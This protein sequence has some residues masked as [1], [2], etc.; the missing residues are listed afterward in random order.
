MRLRVARKVFKKHQA[1]TT[2]Y[3]QS[4][5]DRANKRLGLAPK[6]RMVRHIVIKELAG[7]IPQVTEEARSE[8][9]AKID[10]APQAKQTDTDYS[11]MSVADLK[12]AAKEQ[13]LKGYSKLKKAEL[14]D[15]LQS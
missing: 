4:T 1:Q 15:L 12:A 14:I 11:K 8:A 2:V 10:T 7:V 3:R 5:L 13:G 6:D 9:R